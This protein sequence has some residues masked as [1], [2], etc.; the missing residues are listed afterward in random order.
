M[1]APPLGADGATRDAKVSIQRGRSARRQLQGDRLQDKFQHDMAN[2]AL[3]ELKKLLA[4]RVMARAQ[5][6][7]ARSGNPAPR[8]GSAPT[9]VQQSVVAAEKALRKEVALIADMRPTVKQVKELAT[10]RRRAAAA[11]KAQAKAEAEMALAEV[12]KRSAGA[13]PDAWRDPSWQ[14]LTAVPVA[15]WHR[16]AEAAEAEAAV[17]AANAAEAKAEAKAPARYP[18]AS[19]TP[20]FS[21]AR[22]A[23][24][25]AS[26]LKWRGVGGRRP[27]GG[28]ELRSPKQVVE[29]LREV[30]RE[31]R[32]ELS[33]EEWRA[34]GISDLR[35]DHFVQ[36][37]GGRREAGGGRREAG[38]GG[39]NRGDTGGETG[40]QPRYVDGRAGRAWGE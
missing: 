18:P 14:Q 21:F 5:K 16:I 13:K 29:V 19:V 17:A 28:V 11:Q 9:A 24:A 15:R 32:L 20:S 6:L 1:H 39:E 38:G 2:K 7:R 10:L 37:R 40:Q 12:E 34:L 3:G 8:R 4:V 35:I 25:G 30:L 26:G 31:G 33:R 22:G 27:Q 23:Y 36:A